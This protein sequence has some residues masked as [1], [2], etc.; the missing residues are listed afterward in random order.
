MR[1]GLGGDLFALIEHHGDIYGYNGSGALPVRVRATRRA[2]ARERRRH[3][4]RSG[5]G[6]RV[7]RAARAVR[8]V[9]SRRVLAAGDPAGA[10]RLPARDR[11]GERVGHRGPQARARCARDVPPRRR[12]AHRRADAR[13]TPRKRARSSTLPPDGT[14][15]FYEGWPADAIVRAADRA[16][17]RADDGRS[18]RSSWRMGR[19]PRRGALRRLGDPRATAQR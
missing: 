12:R 18:R 5:P 1:S 11:R 9:G 15:A 19:A 14:R 2:H 8:T 6:R 3:D 17:K 10:Q 7:G 13:P 4:D 16:R